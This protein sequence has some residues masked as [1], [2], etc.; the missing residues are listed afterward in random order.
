MGVTP[1]DPGD[2]DPGANLLQNFPLL[3]SV[4]LDTASTQ[5]QGSLNSI[6][7]TT[8]RL[9][10]FSAPLCDVSGNGPGQRFLGAV[11]RQT[12]AGG[13]VAFV[14]ALPS[15]ALGPFITATATDTAGNTSEFSACLAVPGPTAA[16]ID[17]TSGPA[18][19]ATPV[20]ITG[21]NFQ[22][23][24]VV[25]FGGVAATGV[26][27]LSGTE[28]DAS[29]PVLSPGTLNDVTVTNPSGLAA[30][31]PAAFLADFVD[32]PQASIFH[33]DV[34]TV[35]RAGI[36][37]GCGAGA[38]CVNNA[39]TRAQMAVF[40]LKAEHGSSYVPPNCAGIFDDVECPSQFANW[41]EQLFA[42]GITAGCGGDNYCPN[43]PVRRDQ[44]A[45]FLLKTDE[46]SAYTPPA[47]TTP[48][49]FEDVACPGPFSDW[50]EEL[51][52]RG[53]TG[54]CSTTPLLY[55]PDSSNTRGQMSV[56]LV[57]TFGL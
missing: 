42:E 5:I 34:E 36:T 31:L 57:R 11:D 13:N 47:C 56:F 53:I 22:S 28:I 43:N 17:P 51:Y 54:G 4:Q 12:D 20:S 40:L 46:G 23:G 38:Y 14:A 24:A 52:E 39:V 41:I 26:V 25:R 7:T 33:A 37:A 16:T 27:V 44:M 10:F 1:N 18:S 48:Q 55:C 32:V 21:L 8:Y 49:V 2:P 6:A 35:F 50:I 19:G 45:V 9:E 30:T 29:T 15:A 3:A